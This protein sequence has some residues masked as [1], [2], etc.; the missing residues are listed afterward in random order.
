MIA[1]SKQLQTIRSLVID[2]NSFGWIV[3]NGK[4]E[5]FAYAGKVFTPSGEKTAANAPPGLSAQ[6]APCGDLAPWL[7]AARLITDQHRPELDLILSSA[8]AGPLMRFTGQPGALVSAYSTESG[9]GKTSAMQV[10]QSVFGDPVLAMQA[11]DDTSLSVSNKIGVLRS[12]TIFWD[13]IKTEEDINKFIKL[14]FTVTGGREKTRLTQNIEQRPPGTW[15]TMLIIA[16]NDS[17]VDAVSGALK[18]SE[19][20]AMRLFEYVVTPGV[21]GQIGFGDAGQIIHKTHDNFGRAGEVYSKFLGE[22]FVQVKSDVAKAI[23]SL[24]KV[25]AGKPEERFWFCCAA[26]LIL[27][28]RYANTLK[29]TQIDEQGLVKLCKKIIG[30]MRELRKRLNIN[31]KSGDNVWDLLT[32]FLSSQRARH[33]LTTDTMPLGPGKPAKPKILTDTSRLESVNVH[34]AMK[35]GVMRISRYAMTEWLIAHGHA[36][37]LFTKELEAQF[38]F[39]SVPGANLGGGTQYATGPQYCLEG[40]FVGTPLADW[41]GAMGEDAVLPESFT[42]PEKGETIEKAVARSKLNPLGEQ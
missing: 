32:Q 27:G 30:D 23:N 28:A 18:N 12:L 29:L 20:G 1:W 19:A 40:M 6:Y 15:E 17:L 10:A 33:T 14:A 24:E 39:R 37:H 38:G 26:T 4:E 25:L 22:N 16:S 42:T 11:L 2:T 31:I 41:I 5:G 8:F 9:I 3:N 21:T 36:R 34:L 7:D 35:T 13:E